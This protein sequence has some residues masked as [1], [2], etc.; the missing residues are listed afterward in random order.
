MDNDNDIQIIQTIKLL[1]FFLESVS[2]NPKNFRQMCVFLMFLFTRSIRES[3]WNE[4][5]PTQPP[6]L[7]RKILRTAQ[8]GWQGKPGTPKSVGSDTAKFED[9]DGGIPYGTTLGFKVPEIHLE[10]SITIE[11]SPRDL[12]AMVSF[13]HVYHKKNQ[14]N[15]GI[16]I[17]FVPWILNLRSR[18][19][20][21][22][23]AVFLNQKLKML[24]FY[25]THGRVWEQSE[26]ICF[27][28]LL[29]SYC[30]RYKVPNFAPTNNKNRF[31]PQKGPS[32]FI[33]CQVCMSIFPRSPHQQPTAFASNTGLFTT[34][35]RQSHIPPKVSCCGLAPGCGGWFNQLGS[36]DF[37]WSWWDFV[38]ILQGIFWRG[39]YIIY[40]CRKF[41]WNKWGDIYL[42]GSL[43]YPIFW[44]ANQTFPA[45]VGGKFWG[46]IPP[47]LDSVV[48]TCLFY[49]YIFL[50]CHACRD[51]CLHI[52][53]WS[54]Q[55][56][57]DP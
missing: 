22:S 40:P 42:G 21:G 54:Q 46:F 33:K 24:R 6:P 26:S 12:M 19:V 8:A 23:K 52:W 2:F 5:P 25:S 56:C 48:S 16:D 44:G 51:E 28:K 9:E 50:S 17:P 57:L 27:M 4:P 55:V 10:D 29:Y 13:I 37:V 15:V 45:H 1:V 53:G 35:P 47:V 14:V 31:L 41:C 3:S 7:M 36:S 30:T 20:L 49:V 34:A 18:K 43:N 38:G 32:N 39:R 11:S